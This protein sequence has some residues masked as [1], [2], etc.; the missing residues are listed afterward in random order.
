MKKYYVT[1]NGKKMTLYA[2]C[3]AGLSPH[4]YDFLLKRMRTMTFQDALEKGN[5]E[6]VY[7]YDGKTMPLQRWV[8]L[9][10]TAVSRPAIAD[11]LRRNWTFEEAVTISARKCPTR[12]EIK[13]K[14]FSW[15]GETLSLLD[16]SKKLNCPVTRQQLW[17]R[18]YEYKW[19]IAKA[20]TVPARKIGQSKNKYFTYLGKTLSIRAWA[21]STNPR[22]GVSHTT[23][24]RRLESGMSFQ[25][26]FTSP[27]RENLPFKKKYKF[28]GAWYTAGELSKLDC[29]VVSHSTLI[30][31]LKIKKWT[32]EAALITQPKKR[33][34][35]F[36][37]DGKNQTA[38]TFVYENVGLGS[39]T[40][41][42]RKKR[43]WS[44]LDAIKPKSELKVIKHLFL[45]Q[46]LSL[47]EL[48][49]LPQCRV[50]F[51]TLR[52]RLKLGWDVERAVNEPPRARRIPGNLQYIKFY[53]N[54]PRKPWKV[55]I[56]KNNKEIFVKFCASLKEAIFA[57]DSF[58]KTVDDGDSKLLWKGIKLTLQEIAKLPECVIS[59]KG[60]CKRWKSGDWTLEE[61]VTIKNIQ[62]EKR[63]RTKIKETGA[64]FLH[65]N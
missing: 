60:L 64:G 62:M 65:S 11:R 37:I 63:I 47:T 17:R 24:R 8:N 28:E 3:K 27:S 22:C 4:R 34:Y 20:M 7:T 43:G 51:E 39:T 58:L 9:G 40:F 46:S 30:E 14:Y 5:G 33:P 52:H 36:M 54:C 2:Y 1:H 45:G 29:C 16:W 56:Q 42:H 44:D 21:K 13:N 61:C 23:L 53:K 50:G 49:K 31:R 41:Y 57:R 35:K 48:S 19:S 26:A 38:S 15:H 6:I 12:F 55:R 32:V 59:Y 18:I 25:Q 10:L